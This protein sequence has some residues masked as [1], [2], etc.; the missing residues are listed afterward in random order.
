M[1]AKS[2]RSTGINASPKRTVLSGVKVTL[3]LR[4]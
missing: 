4:I 1:K 3:N 2:V